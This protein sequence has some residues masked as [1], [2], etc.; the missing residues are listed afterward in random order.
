[1][2]YSN[3]WFSAHLDLPLVYSISA[4][5]QESGQGGGAQAGGAWLGRASLCHMVWAWG[6]Q[7]AVMTLHALLAAY[8]M[9]WLL[10]SCF[11][12]PPLWKGS[13]SQCH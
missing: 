5:L 1:M 12:E 7:L 3:K 8:L 10:L 2:I 4:E 9:D 6:L 13:F 11:L